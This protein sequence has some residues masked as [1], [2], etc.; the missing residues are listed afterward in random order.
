METSKR[1][2]RIV[3]DKSIL[4]LGVGESH[5]VCV[6]VWVAQIE[7]IPTPPTGEGA[8]ERVRERESL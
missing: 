6:C 3:Y 7:S 8:T 4:G 2:V 5:C 1:F